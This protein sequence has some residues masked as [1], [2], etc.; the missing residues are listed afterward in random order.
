MIKEVKRNGIMVEEKERQVGSIY[1]DEWE[2]QKVR[3]HN[4]D[5]QTQQILHYKTLE[6]KVICNNWSIQKIQ[7]PSDCYKVV[8]ETIVN[9]LCSDCEQ[10]AMYDTEQD[11]FYCPR[12]HE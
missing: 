8:K 7:T 2:G 10:D 5:E 4:H 12:C 6:E 9:H 11:E 3:F 1:E